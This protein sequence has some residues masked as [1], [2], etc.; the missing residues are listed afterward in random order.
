MLGL[1]AESNNYTSN[2]NGYE[3]QV[4]IGGNTDVRFRSRVK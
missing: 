3:K 1:G 2:C 4:R